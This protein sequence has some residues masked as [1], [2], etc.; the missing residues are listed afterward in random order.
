MRRSRMP[1]S[2]EAARRRGSRAS[3]NLSWRLCGLAAFLSL[4]ACD[5]SKGPPPHIPEVPIDQGYP[6]RSA[7]P[8]AGEGPGGGADSEA[9]GGGAEGAAGGGA[10][11][12][13]AGRR[14]GGAA[15]AA[16]GE[17]GGGGDLPVQLSGLTNVPGATDG[18]QGGAVTPGKP[19]P[20][21]A[22]RLTSLECKKIMD[23]Y[24][25]LVGISQGISPDA[26]AGVMDMLRNSVSGDANY[27][28][29][30]NSCAKENTKTQYRC[31]IR[32]SDVDGWKKC[33]Q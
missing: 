18:P 19:L 11:G 13:G 14:T 32:A 29:A 31:A 2:R 24:I 21:K 17:T 8:L 23:K 22:E 5:A 25:E 1:P 15:A 3:T 6:P 4:A 12:G 10:A 9:N 26:I 16:S 28:N 20:P 7:S 33:L 27:A 30:L